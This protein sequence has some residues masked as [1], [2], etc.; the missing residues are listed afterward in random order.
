M[1]ALLVHPETPESF[2][3]LR[4]MCDLEGRK[5]LLP[6][7]GLITMAAL[8]PQEWE[9]RLVDM[10]V[11]P[12]TNNDWE[13]ADLILMSGMA[14]QREA[15][16]RIIREAKARGKKI[17]VGGPYA[18]AMP[19]ELLGTDCD[20]VVVGEAETT[21]A[22]LLAAL[23]DGSGDRL[24]QAPERPALTESPVPR[25]DLLKLHAYVLMAFQTS[26]G[27]P[28]DCDFCEIA[29]LY[30]SRPRFKSP[31]QIIRELDKLYSIGW[32]G[33]V[34]ISDD[35]F[36]GKRSHTVGVLEKLTPWLVEHGYPFSFWT[37]TSVNLGQDI[38]LI[39][40]M[41]A[42]NFSNVFV[43]IESPDEDVLTASR[44]FQN[45]KNPLLESVNNI[46]RNGLTVIGSFIIGFDGERP[47]LGDRICAFID[48]ANLPMVMLNVLQPI[49]NT[50]LWERL[51]QEG[52]LRPMQMLGESI[53]GRLNFVPLRPEAEIMA[54]YL[55]VWDYVYEPSNFLRRTYQYFLYMRPT[56][57]A[58]AQAHG[59]AVKPVNL[60][61][62]SMEE[63]L[64]RLGQLLR[65]FWWQGTKSRCRFQFW[66]QLFGILRKNPSRKVRYL[67]GCA[68][69][70][71]L[72]RLTPEV[73]QRIA[74]YL[75][76]RPSV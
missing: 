44:K 55:R 54:D 15:I 73:R 28:H 75:T 26:R 60:A 1:K 19:E 37:Q 70:E 63:S 11:Q 51:E 76:D 17:V 41:T 42:A 27:C 31:E 49:P 65:L 66:K 12:L 23:T 34:F 58:L 48:A 71:A 50:R 47:G 46:T 10:N 22:M 61:A 59:E 13:W 6:P 52:R 8:L 53:A 56:R 4:L 33:Y 20:L 30:G 45:V 36:V 5:T 24:I 62:P 38:P 67:Q 74:S 57:K 35:N 9:L 43:G 39:D 69:G 25:F 72:F 40:M 18:T 64:K 29:A 68:F 32:R 14:I 2:W 7:L 21:I 3:S 16:F